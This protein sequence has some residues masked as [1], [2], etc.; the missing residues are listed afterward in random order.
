MATL[1]HNYDNLH[2]TTVLPFLPS[3]QHQL[4]MCGTQGLKTHGADQPQQRQ[5]QQLRQATLQAKLQPAAVLSGTLPI[6]KPRTA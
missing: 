6:S 4:T 5:H 3:T 1:R 2:N